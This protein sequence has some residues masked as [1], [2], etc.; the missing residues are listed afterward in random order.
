MDL[1]VSKPKGSKPGVTPPD[2]RSAPCRV[3]K[4]DTC[5]PT[6]F[7]TCDC[8]MGQNQMWSD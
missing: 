4:H 3:G 6:Q 8:H 7:C 5:D 2:A 1:D